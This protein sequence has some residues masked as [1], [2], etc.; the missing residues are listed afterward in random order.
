MEVGDKLVCVLNIRG[1]LSAAP[2]LYP[3]K[4]YT[5]VDTAYFGIRNETSFYYIEEHPGH[6]YPKESFITFDE[7]RRNKLLKIKEKIND[8]SR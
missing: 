3:H 1:A 7:Y 5:Y 8:L 6:S 2:R 4:V